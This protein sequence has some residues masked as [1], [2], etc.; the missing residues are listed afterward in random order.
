MT[1]IL[2]LYY[3]RYGATRTMA[4]HIA[5]GVESIA[6]IEAKLRTVPAVSPTNEAVDPEVPDQG[7]AYAFQ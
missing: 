7:A 2:V 5:R 3:S 1:S 4:Q 6:G